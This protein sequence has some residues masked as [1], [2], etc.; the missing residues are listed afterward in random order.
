[1]KKEKNN[2]LFEGIRGE[3]LKEISNLHKIPQGAI[4]VRE[5]GKSTLMNSTADIEIIKKKKRSGIDIFVKPNVKN[6]S[7]HIP[8]IITENGVS[9]VVYNDFYIGENS[10]LLIVAGC[11]IHIT[12]GKSVHNGIHSFHLEKNAKV[13]YVERHLGVGAYEAEKIL[14]PQTNIELKENAV[15][16]METLQIGGVSSSDRKTNAVLDKSSKLI[17]KEKILTTEN[18]FAKSQFVAICEGENSKCEIVSRSV[19][20]DNSRQEFFSN[21]IGENVCFGRVECDAILI[22]NAKIVS[23]PQITANSAS[24]E[25][26][27]EAQIGKIASEQLIKLQTL[28]LSEEEAENLIIEGYLM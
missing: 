24:A 27:H 8:V 21:L 11:G 15:L 17:I 14:N 13:R 25:L 2:S 4:S 7:L 23:T 12:E 6:K 20:K 19:A 9:D 28:G 3:L 22:D 16:E 26:A 1:M 18:Q 10:E 5:N